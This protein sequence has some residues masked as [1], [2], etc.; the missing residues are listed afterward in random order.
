[1]PN[2]EDHYPLSLLAGFEL[3]PT[4][5][6][7]G[8]MA[9]CRRHEGEVSALI[10]DSLTKGPNLGSLAFMAGEHEAEHHGGPAMPSEAELNTRPSS[11]ASPKEGSDA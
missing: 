7:D 11:T 6:G 1:M 10:V 9:L 4:G 8:V 3:M 5:S 2:S